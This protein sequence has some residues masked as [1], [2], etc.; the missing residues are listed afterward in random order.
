MSEPV[1]QVA[2]AGALAEDPARSHPP[3]FA[4]ARRLRDTLSECGIAA[5]EPAAWRNAGWRVPL[6][7]DTFELQVAPLTP[8]G[9]LLSVAPL[10]QPGAFARLLGKRRREVVPSLQAI[11]EIVHEVISTLPQSDAVRWCL[12][13]HPDQGA[14][15]TEPSQLPWPRER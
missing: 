5:S 12:N 11:C 14:S 1:P 2:F 13:A 15:V 4:L 6:E 10:G 3:G 8:T 7:Q 9:W